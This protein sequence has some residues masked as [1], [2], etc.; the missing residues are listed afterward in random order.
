MYYHIILRFERQKV[1]IQINHFELLEKLRVVN[2]EL[3]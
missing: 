3:S 1:Y 2:I